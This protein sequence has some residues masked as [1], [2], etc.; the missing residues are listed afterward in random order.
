MG[1]SHNIT[2][3]DYDLESRNYKS[4]DALTQDVIRGLRVA[5]A[6]IVR[7][8]YGQHTVFSM[9]K[10]LEPYLKSTETTGGA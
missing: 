4:E 6:C 9:T 3:A 5:G 1:S 2:T 8:L 10:E 7:N